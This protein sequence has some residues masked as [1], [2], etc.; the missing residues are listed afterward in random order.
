MSDEQVGYGYTNDEEQIDSGGFSLLFGLN[1]GVTMTKFEYIKNGGKDGA[2][3]EAL[4]IALTLADGSVKNMRKFPI[5]KA[6]KKTERGQPQEEITDP[7]SPEMQEAFKD[8][9][10]VITHVM[11]CFVS[12]EDYK[13]A[14]SKPVASFEHFCKILMGLLPTNY[15][16]VKLDLFAQYQWQI[17]GENS[18]TYLEIPSKMKYG[19]FLCVSPEAKDFDP[20]DQSKTIPG[21]W[22]EMRKT[23]PQDNDTMA[24]YYTDGIGTLHPFIRNGWFVKSNF[25]NQQKEDAPSGGYNTAFAPPAATAEGAPP[26]GPSKGW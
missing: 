11:H 21:V 14:L 5:L 22:K 25:A 4:D 23:D 26:A 19:R 6:F 18:K 24:L 20:Q 15:N 17:K 10:A 16:T 3:Q 1:S 8:L 7:K 13:L 2:E 9:N 12:D